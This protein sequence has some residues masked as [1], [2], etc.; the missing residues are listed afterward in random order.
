M[1]APPLAPCINQERHNPLNLLCEIL[2]YL[3]V[4]SIDRWPSRMPLY[5]LVYR[6]NNLICVV[7]EPGASVQRDLPIMTILVSAEGVLTHPMPS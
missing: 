7:I 1:L 5:W 6:H 4:I 2:V 3:T